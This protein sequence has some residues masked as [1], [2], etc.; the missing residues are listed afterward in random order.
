MYNILK[1]VISR[2]AYNF[3]DINIQIPVHEAKVPPKF[4]IRV[5]KKEQ[6]PDNLSNVE[7][8]SAGLWPLNTLS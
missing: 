5:A 2:K 7:N 6:I 1:N 8:F 3:T 4:H